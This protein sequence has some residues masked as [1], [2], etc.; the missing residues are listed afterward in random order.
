MK[1]DYV[2]K[3][4][5][6]SACRN[7]RANFFTSTSSYALRLDS[8]MNTNVK[9]FGWLEPDELKRKTQEASQL[10]SIAEVEGKQMSSKIFGY[11]ATGKPVVHIYTAED[12]VNMRYLQHYPLA[13][14]LKADPL[15]IEQNS[16]LLSLWCVWSYGQRVSWSDV[17]DEFE[18]LTP[19]FVAKKLLSVGAFE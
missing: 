19:E 13:L 18:D 12:D 2:C 5:E 10:L 1:P 15:K 4:L 8:C 14:C 3:M 9:R 16:R 11:I 17:L 7:A 6:C